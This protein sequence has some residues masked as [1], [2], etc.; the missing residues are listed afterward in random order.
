MSWASFPSRPWP[1]SSY[2]SSAPLSMSEYR[3]S[4]PPICALPIGIRFL[5]MNGFAL[6][7]WIASRIARTS[8]N[9]L[10]NPTAF[11]KPVR[12]RAQ[13]VKGSQTPLWNLYRGIT[14]PRT[15]NRS[16]PK[17]ISGY[18]YTDDEYTGTLVGSPA[19]FT[20]LSAAT[21]FYYEGR[22]GTFTAHREHR[23]RGTH[24]WTA[25]RR[26]LGIL[27]RVYLGKA[28]L[29]TPQRLEEVALLLTTL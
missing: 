9:L 22:L 29:L 26:Q 14:M 19:W 20:W 13:D 25:Y 27:Y 18:I 21:T 15:E 8:W 5:A 24:Y 23:Q 28:D 11:V 17:I 3:C 1:P 10:A 4:S 6:P 12:S 7:C 16:T 2:S